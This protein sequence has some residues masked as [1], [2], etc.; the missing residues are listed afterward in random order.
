MADHRDVLSPDLFSHGNRSDLIKLP[1]SR[2]RHE[3]GVKEKQGV[4]KTEMQERW[5]EHFSE[6]L[7]R[8]DPRWNFTTVLKDL[9][10]ADDIAL[11]S[12]KTSDLQEKTGR[13][14]E[15]A[16]GVG[17]KRNARKPLRTEFAHRSEDVVVNG[18]E[19]EDD[20]E[21]VYLGATA[22]KEGGGDKDITN[23]LHKA[24]GAF[25]R[26]GKVWATRGIGKRTKI[27]L[28]KTSTGPAIWM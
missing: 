2:G 18:E 1:H 23:R 11:L 5:V 16:A 4:L 9:D 15:E 27:R 26:L 19:V 7:N 13:L 10:F 8:D 20:E 3:I 12:S 14:A 24:R 21:F 28:F 22:N 6:K 17:L 25:Q